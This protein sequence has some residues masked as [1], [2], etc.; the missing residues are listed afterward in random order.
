MQWEGNVKPPPKSFGLLK[1]EPRNQ[2]P[3]LSLLVVLALLGTGVGL[4][5]PLLFKAFIDNA[6]PRADLQ[7]IGLLLAGMVVVPGVERQS[8]LRQPLSA[9]IYR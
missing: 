9:R 4:I 5:Q 1:E 3:R 7:L 6:S 8:Q 2:T